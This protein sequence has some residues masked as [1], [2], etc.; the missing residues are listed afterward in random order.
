MTANIGTYNFIASSVVP[1][2]LH[3]QINDTATTLIITGYTSDPVS[4]HDKIVISIT[5]YKPVPGTYSIVQGQA[6]G[7]YYHNIYNSFALGGVV[8]ISKVTNTSLIGYFSFN[9]QD[10]L[11]VINGAFNVG[12]P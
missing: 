5:S 11:A 4:P 2:T 1:S 6:S 7:A 9:T 12:L 8:S 3:S 10:G